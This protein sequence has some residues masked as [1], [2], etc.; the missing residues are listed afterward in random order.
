[1]PSLEFTRETFVLQ[2]KTKGYKVG[3]LKDGIR[4][5]SGP[6]LIVK[7][8]TFCSEQGPIHLTGE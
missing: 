5:A 7:N 6:L 1:M 3:C 4:Y 2:V 8:I